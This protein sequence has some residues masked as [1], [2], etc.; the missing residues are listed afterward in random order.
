MDARWD[1]MAQQ[2]PSSS[3]VK[4]GL[5]PERRLYL[6]S[7]T[8][9]RYARLSPLVQIYV[10]IAIVALFTWTGL[11]SIGYLEHNLALRTAAM[12]RD[13]LEAAYSVRLQRAEADRAA[14]LQRAEEAEQRAAAA[15]QR[16]GE[17]QHELVGASARLGA[18]EHAL[19][20]LREKIGALSEARRRAEARERSLASALAEMKQ[21]LDETRSRSADGG[22]AVA[23]L[24][25]ALDRVIAE[26][27]EAAGLAE[28]LSARV[29]ALE[30]EVG[31]WQARKADL[32][33]RI[34]R[35][36][37]KSLNDYEAVFERVG[38]D[39]KKIATETRAPAQGGPFE[40]LD[41]EAE[42][43]LDIGTDIRLA[44]LMRDL[45]QANLLRIAAD[46]LP[47]AMPVEGAR[48]T[49]GFGK[50]RD[51]FRGRWSMHNGVDWAGP[52]GTP[53]KAT[54]DG[55]VSFAGR[56]SGYGKI[57]II[58][59]AFGYET[60]YAHL[61]RSRVK[62][63]QR[64]ERGAVIGDM[65]NTGR[66]TGTHLHYEVRVD[67]RPIDPEKFIKAARKVL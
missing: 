64:V 53:I 2:H 1:M 39:P 61:K 20:G 35:A 23:T 50:R 7:E 18:T 60:R 57:V 24:A 52:S 48:R 36:A 8:R 33:N 59:H 51:P 29:A 27:D 37:Q 9:T 67:D 25:G 17:T 49:S 5:I 44:A 14:L 65:G 31:D 63:G 10:F 30:A 26:R 12:K 28:A 41:P 11:A 56:Q 55:V 58:Q 42:A 6:R 13:A 22:A 34:E 40:P 62:V 46:R 15:T 45:E 4:A 16:L 19:A 47:F 54:A 3:T 43:G 66:S 38:L 32:F 21:A